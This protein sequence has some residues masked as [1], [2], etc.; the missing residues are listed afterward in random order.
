MPP[1]LDRLVSLQACHDLLAGYCRALDWLDGD[2]L[3]RMFWPDAAIDY[4][5]YTGDFAGFLPIVMDIERGALRRWHG[6]LSALVTVDGDVAAGESHALTHAVTGSANGI[7][8][9]AAYHGRYLDRFARREGEW[10]IAARTYLLH[11]A[12]TRDVDPRAALAGLA[13]ADGLAP[14]HPFYREMRP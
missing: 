11:A 4:G 10:R 14:D 5:F 9:W 8:Q 2:A 1:D 7:E 13:A 3:A 12:E 6:C